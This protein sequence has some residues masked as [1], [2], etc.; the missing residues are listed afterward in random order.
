[1]TQIQSASVQPS[2]WKQLSYLSFAV[3]WWLSVLPS[4]VADASRA[5]DGQLGARGA[6]GC[7]PIRAAANCEDLCGRESP[8]PSAALDKFLLCS[9]I[10]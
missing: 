4:P 10:R 2:F 6:D 9:R 5:S 1:M 8:C 7:R 3:G